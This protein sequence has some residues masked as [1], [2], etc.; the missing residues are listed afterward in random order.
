MRARP[1]RIALLEVAWL[2][3]VLLAAWF[4]H[5]G[6]RAEV[7]APA[8][9]TPAV[10]SVRDAAGHRVALRRFERIASSSTVADAL[11]LEL[12]EPERIVALSHHGRER[13]AALQYG[14]RP[15]LAGLSPLELLL[16]LRPDLVLVNR[17]VGQ[18]ELAR[19]RAVG[20]TVFTMGDMRGLTTLLHDIDVIATLLG[21]R[22]RGQRF[23]AQLTRRMRAVAADI[24]PDRRRRALYVS[25]LGGKLFGGTVGTSYHDVLVHAG[26]RDVAA[27]RFRDWPHY[28]P[29]Q[30]LALDPDLIV[31]P[32]GLSAGLCAVS[33]LERLRACKKQGVVELPESLLGDPGPRMLEAAERL[34]DAVYGPPLPAL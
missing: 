29:E 2:S 23:A 7:S 1:G 14:N 27:E 18:A 28:D 31:T 25:A 22:A 24:P 17:L 34:R 19:A 20:L 8:S 21:D 26:L 3:L 16:S 15:T 13:S 9:A 33:G 12:A 6:E 30:L 32:E 4:T 11:L 10:S 5:A